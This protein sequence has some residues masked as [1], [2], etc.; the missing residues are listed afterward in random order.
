MSLKIVTWNVNGIRS[1]IFNSEVNN[2][3]KKNH[4][5]IPEEN[6]SMSNLL[7]HNPDIIRLQEIRTDR[8]PVSSTNCLPSYIVASGS[9]DSI[10]SKSNGG[11]FR[12]SN[13]VD[14]SSHGGFCRVSWLKQIYMTID[15][16]SRVICALKMR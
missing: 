4:I 10:P 9:F 8:G 3:L 1:R 2:K 15:Y 6:S 5:F 14:Y 7:K 13:E 12:D 16:E 11:K